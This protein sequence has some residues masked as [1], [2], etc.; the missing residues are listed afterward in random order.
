MDEQVPF[1]LDYMFRNIAPPGTAPGSVMAATSKVD[2]PY[3][4][5][6]IRDAALTMDVVVKLYSESANPNTTAFYEKTLW[7]F[8]RLSRSQQ[9]AKGCQPYVSGVCEAL[10]GPG[11]VKYN[12][13]GSVFTG[14]WGRLQNDGPAL[15]ASTLIRFAEAYLKKGGDLKVVRERLYD[16]V[17]P[18]QTTV[19]VDLEYVGHVWK[20]KGFDL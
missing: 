13:D 5:H 19:K 2:P 20:N 14:P 16:G 1:S 9:S 17:L 12:P 15:R 11:E 10:G 8:A 7:D 3:F 18:S 6:W 4:F